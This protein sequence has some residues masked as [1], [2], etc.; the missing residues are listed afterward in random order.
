MKIFIDFDDVIF[1][2]GKFKKIFLREVFVKNG[3]TEKDFNETYY[4]FFKKNN[5][6]DKYYNPQKQI[7]ALGKKDYIKIDKL[8]ND[9]RFFMRDLKKYVFEDVIYFLEKFNRKDL[10]MISY[11]D[12]VFHKMKVKGTDTSKFFKEIILGKMN[13]MDLIN[14][15]LKKYKLSSDE[16]IFIIDDIPKHLRKKGESKKR[17]VTLHLKRPEGRY[18]D[19]IC[20]NADYEIKNL[21]EALKIINQLK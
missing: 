4:H 18:K 16:K 11:G 14:E 13:K 10:F 17:M 19:L 7:E 12:Q 1:N 2:T 3:A 21:K 5:K 20:K 15:T 9:F 8:K 6:I